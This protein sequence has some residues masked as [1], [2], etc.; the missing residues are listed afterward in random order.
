[1]ALP[2]AT[3]GEMVDVIGWRID[4]VVKLI[5]GPKGTKVRLQLLPASTGV[6]GPSTTISLVRDKIKLE[7]QSAKKKMIESV[8]NGPNSEAWR[9][10]TPQFL[11][12]FYGPIKK[13]I[14]TTTAQPVM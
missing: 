3:R 7:D 8:Q 11:H 9:C 4:E 10:N 1:L 14:L 2:R 6:N 12:G 5:K 13:E